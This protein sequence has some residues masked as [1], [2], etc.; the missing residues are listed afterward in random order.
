MTQVIIPKYPRHSQEQLTSAANTWRL[1]YWD[2]AVT[3][4]DSRRRSHY[5]VPKLVRIKKI[6]LK[7][8]DGLICVDNP[9]YRFSMP[10]GQS[11]GAYGIT[12]IKEIR[13]L[14]SWTMFY[15]PIF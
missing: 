15:E 1:P 11:M 6:R 9:M 13:V 7:G 8:P 3:K 14:C 10:G 2:W 5:N 4:S 12:P